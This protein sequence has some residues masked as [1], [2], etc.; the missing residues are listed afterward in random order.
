MMNTKFDWRSNRQEI[1]KQMII[2]K[3]SIKIHQSKKSMINNSINM[4]QESEKVDGTFPIGF[5]GQKP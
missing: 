5:R 4:K 1:R 2:E 3:K